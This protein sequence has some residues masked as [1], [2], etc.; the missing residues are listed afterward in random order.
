MENIILSFSISTSAVYRPILVA[1]FF[2]GQKISE[3]NEKGEYVDLER[4][5]ADR[6]K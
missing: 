2:S 4:Y 6:E 1:D 5:D 3:L